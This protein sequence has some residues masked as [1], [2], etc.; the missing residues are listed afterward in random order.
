VP[1]TPA[2]I[3][4]LLRRQMLR[5]FRRPLIIMSPKS[6][7]RHKQ[8]V[9]SR[10]ELAE[11]QFQLVVDDQQ[12]DPDKVTRVILCSGRVYYDLLAARE[13]AELTAEVALLRIEQLYPFPID[14]ASAAL[15]RYPHANRVIWTQEEP[16]NQGAWYSS[17]HHMSSSLADHQQLGFAGRPHSASP[18]VGYMARHQ[19][20]LHALLESALRGDHNE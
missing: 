2:Q 13:E 18:A 15:A 12:V 20:Q 19:A 9:S 4:H 11:Q 1:S 8:A 10:E 3:F 17:Q 7:L 14:E 6:L 5:P 16:Q